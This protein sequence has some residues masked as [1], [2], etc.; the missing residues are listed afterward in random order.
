[1]FIV[2]TATSD[3]RTKNRTLTE[4]HIAETDSSTKCEWRFLWKILFTSNTHMLQVSIKFSHRS[5]EK[6]ESIAKH[7][8]N[9]LHLFQ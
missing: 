5:G 6:T 7:N 8:Q 9:K 1:M 3:I 2:P 4:T